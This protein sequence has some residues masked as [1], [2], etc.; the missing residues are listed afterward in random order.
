MLSAAYIYFLTSLVNAQL[1]GVTKPEI[2]YEM[3]NMIKEYFFIRAVT[4]WG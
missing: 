3:F 2:N 1:V 4:V